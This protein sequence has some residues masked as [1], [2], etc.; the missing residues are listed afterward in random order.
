MPP[1]N[2]NKQQGNKI[3]WQNLSLGAI[4]HNIRPAEEMLRKL[5]N[6][7]ENVTTFPQQIFSS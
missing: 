3:S 2:V 6:A 7:E 1:N 5:K 4:C